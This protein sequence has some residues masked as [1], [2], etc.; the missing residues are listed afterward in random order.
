MA[1]TALVAAAPEAS[2]NART[3]TVHTEALDLNVRSAP[4]VNSQK[5]GSVPTETQVV[6]VCFAQGEPF[7]GGPYHLTTTIWNQLEGGGFVTDAMLNTG[8]NGPVVPPCVSEAS[9]PPAASTMSAPARLPAVA[10]PAMG[11]VQ[12]TNDA[13]AGE[14]TWGAYEKWFQSSGNRFYPDLSGEA[15]DW[16]DSARA[17]GWTVTDDPHSRA[18]V[19]FQPGVAG[20]PSRGHVGWVDSTSQRPDGVYLHVT[21]MNASGR[22][23]KTWTARNVKSGPGMS[24]ILLP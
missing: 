7:T 10:G 19:V 20:A 21:D 16:A 18:I 24:Y 8:S 6:I 14:C 22:D 17:A 2:A 23:P 1:P 11:K 13:V 12:K 15:K 9:K 5:I 3:V 4:S